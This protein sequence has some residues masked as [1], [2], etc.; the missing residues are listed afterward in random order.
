MESVKCKVA[1]PRDFAAAVKDIKLAILQARAS[2]FAI[3][4]LATNEIRQT[5]SD[6]F[7]Y[8]PSSKKERYL[9]SNEFDKSKIRQ[10]P[11][12]EIRPTALG[13]TYC[14]RYGEFRSLGERVLGICPNS[15][16]RILPTAKATAAKVIVLSA[17]RRCA[18]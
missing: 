7:C 14:F 6:E 4:S 1:V 11:F 18:A 8:L 16:T 9:P 10:M 3:R 12:A 2:M 17:R 5:A 13:G 15:Q